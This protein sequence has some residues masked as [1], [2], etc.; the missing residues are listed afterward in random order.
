M[1]KGKPNK[2]PSKGQT[3]PGG[4]RAKQ[5]DKAATERVRCTKA[6]PEGRPAR[7]S[8]KEHESAHG[9]GTW[10]W[11][12]QIRKGR[13]RHQHDRA[14]VHWPSPPWNDGRY[15]KPAAS[16]TGSTQSTQRKTDAGGPC[17]NNPIAGPRTGT[18]RSEPSQAQ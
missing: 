5:K 10:A 9:H 15:A 13:C 2:R 1:N 7:P 4:G 17:Q 8:E 14:L 11:H 18:T 3:R 6:R 16:V 12:P